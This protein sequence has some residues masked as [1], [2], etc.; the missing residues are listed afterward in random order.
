[1]AEVPE[2]HSDVIGE[3]VK[4]IDTV[5]DLAVVSRVCS[6]WRLAALKEENWVSGRQLP[7]LV[8]PE[9]KEEDESKS[10]RGFF[11]L[12][13]NKRYDLDVPELRGCRIWGSNHGWIVAFGLDLQIHL[14]NPL[15]RSK[16]S[17]PPHS[18]FKHQRP[19]YHPSPQWYREAFIHKALVLKR[20]NLSGQQLLV[21]ALYGRCNYLAIARP[22]DETWTEVESEYRCRPSRTI[23]D[24]ACCN[25][26]IFALGSCGTLLLCEFDGPKPPN[27]IIFAPPPADIKS[28]NK[29]YLVESMGDLL[30]VVRVVD[31]DDD[32]GYYSDYETYAFDV[33][34]FD[35][36]TKEWT[37]LYDLGDRALFIGDSYSMCLSSTEVAGCV[38]NRIYFTDDNFEQWDRDNYG[39]HES[40]VYDMEEF[41]IDRLPL[42]NCIGDRLRSAFECPVWLM[43]SLF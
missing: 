31:E 10:S 4:R 12:Y 34:Q 17:L 6:S 30:M 11:S 41:T 35:F 16:F 43:P 27:S 32:Y 3:I 39:G 21:A 2:L 22:G 13:K 18:T 19:K 29:L 20:P 15:S 25:G 28:A 26:Q 14:V 8:L 24:V 37:E 42:P 40:G 1:M 23:Q 9:T 7:W 5:E 36:K 33:H 38:G